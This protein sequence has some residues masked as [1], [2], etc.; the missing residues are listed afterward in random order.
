MSPLTLNGMPTIGSPTMRPTIGTR[1]S[2]ALT[3]T[4]GS[5]MPVSATL[6]VPEPDLALHR[7]VERPALEQGA[8]DERALAEKPRVDFDRAVGHPVAGSTRARR[9]AVA[10]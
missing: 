9:S 5:A 7:D 2:N 1:R 3:F 8:V 10:R 4:M 6:P